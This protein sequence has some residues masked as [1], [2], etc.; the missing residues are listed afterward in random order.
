MKNFMIYLTVLLFISF[1]AFIPVNLPTLTDDEKA[2]LLL[3]REE[4]KLANEVY[5]AMYNKWNHRVFNNIKES[6]AYHAELVKGLITKYKLQDPYISEFGKY[7]NITLQELYNDLVE[8][9]NKSINDAFEVGAIIEDMD[10]ADLDRLLAKTENADLKQVYETLNLGSRN[11][12]RAFV[13]N[14]RNNNKNYEP[15]YISKERFDSI[16][17]GQHE[18]CTDNASANSKG[19]A[20]MACK[21]NNS[22]KACAG[23]GGSKNCGQGMGPNSI[24]KGCCK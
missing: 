19:N 15:K 1:T 17:N 22:K 10:I 23:N 11:H 5:T 12:M 2:G 14:L 8:K 24:K 21:G 9:G 13:K 3:M 20:G 16:I 7:R 4:E 6:E 18:T